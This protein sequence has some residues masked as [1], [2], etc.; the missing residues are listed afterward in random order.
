MCPY[1][2]PVFNHAPHS[3]F[4]IWSPHDV[5]LD[6]V[7][8]LENP[9]L[10]P[11][12]FHAL[13]LSRLPAP[14]L[15]FTPPVHRIILYPHTP[16]S[17]GGKCQLHAQLDWGAV[18]SAYRQQQRAATA[19]AGGRG[20]SETIGARAPANIG[21]MDRGSETIGARAPAT[22]GTMGR[23][24]ETVGARVFASVGT[25]GSE[26]VSRLQS[27]S[28]FPG[29]VLA[30]ELISRLAALPPASVRD[31]TRACAAAASAS[32]FY[33]SAATA[34]IARTS[35]EGGG[36]S[37]GGWSE[38]TVGGS[39][40]ASATRQTS[41]GI[42]GGPPPPGDNGA[43]LQALASTIMKVRAGQQYIK[44]VVVQALYKKGPPSPCGLHAPF[45]APPTDSS[46]LSP[47]S[48]PPSPCTGLHGHILSEGLGYGG[49]AG[50]GCVCPS[51]R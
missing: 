51:A 15:P 13:P 31:V 41:S 46:P 42:G 17:S 48:L 20:G 45:T 28:L 21:A 34:A 38:V 4:T 6:L 49:G 37:G 33:D 2:A 40:R 36:G 25:R 14:P 30:P 22:V 9:P 12:P 19:A 47:L 10:L 23:G 24:S 44:C 50:T 39:R 18:L 11:L 43:L 16:G 1:H 5:I 26:T 27:Q 29:L 3:V 8:L 7:F 32:A 35:D